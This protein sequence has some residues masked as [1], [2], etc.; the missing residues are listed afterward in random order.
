MV[1]I[2]QPLSLIED[3]SKMV[4]IS[5]GNCFAA[6][7]SGTSKALVAKE[8]SQLR[9]AEVG[10]KSDSAPKCAGKVAG[11]GMAPA[12]HRLHSLALI[13]ILKSIIIE[14]SETTEK[15]PPVHHSRSRRLPL[16]CWE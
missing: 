9:N 7:L 12:T 1:S 4:L 16:Q 14:I 5:P 3:P 15:P 2:Y 13:N 10:N 11:A 8:S 6:L